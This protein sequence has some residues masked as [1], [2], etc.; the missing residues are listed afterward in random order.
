MRK[1]YLL[2]IT[3]FCLLQ[4]LSC[5]KDQ[6]PV[7]PAQPVKQP[8]TTLN[9]G[10]LIFS[11]DGEFVGSHID[12]IA[13]IITVTIARGSDLHSRKADFSLASQVKASINNA[14]V[15]SGITLDL[16]Q[17]TTFTVTSE[18]GKLSTAFKVTTQTEFGY[19]GIPGTIIAEKSLN[20]SFDFYYDQIDGSTFASVNCG[21]TVATMAAKWADSSFTKKPVD[22]RNLIRA[23]GTMWYTGDIQSYLH[24]DGIN[25][26]NDTL[27]D[28]QGLVKNCI[29]H[30][31]LLVLCLDMYKVPHNP[32]IYQ[33]THKFYVT[34]YPPWPHFILVKGYKQTEDNFYLEIYDPYS[35]GMRYDY[36]F[37]NQLKGIDRYYSTADLAQA[38]HDWWPYAIIIAPKGQ[39]TVTSTRLQVN[40]I[41]KDIPQAYGR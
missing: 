16:S 25:S 28:M 34:T 21:P 8:I 29:D 38:T 17:P 27:S 5:K 30:N 41:H 33:H 24:Y 11:V 14:S 39:K 22:A 2:F 3:A 37:N 6:K 40:S 36:L 1:K 31:N 12:T 10:L 7:P 35:Y 32:K 18:D 20:K 15:Q 9:R 13:D 23:E 19:M 4:V 26:T